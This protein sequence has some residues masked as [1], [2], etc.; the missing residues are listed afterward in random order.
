MFEFVTVDEDGHEER[1]TAE[2][3][4]DTWIMVD[5]NYFR[6]CQRETPVQTVNILET[7]ESTSE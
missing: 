4:S 1:E 5:E 3:C 2:V 7:M 6:L